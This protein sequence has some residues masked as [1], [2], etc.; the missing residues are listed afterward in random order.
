MNR[1]YLMLLISAMTFTACL[2]NGPTAQGQMF[3][4]GRNADDRP[5][6]AEVMKTARQN[7]TEKMPVK[8]GEGQLIF[9]FPTYENVEETCKSVLGESYN[10]SRSSI[11]DNFF[12]KYQNG[13][14]E[15]VVKSGQNQWGQEIDDLKAVVLSDHSDSSN[16]VEIKINEQAGKLSLFS[17]DLARQK[18]HILRQTRKNVSLVTVEGDLFEYMTGETIKDL[19]TKPNFKSTVDQFR[20]A[21]IGL[22]KIASGSKI[23]KWIESILNFNDQDRQKFEEAFPDLNSKKF[24]LRKQAAKALSKDIAGHSIAIT[25]ML[26]SDDLPLE[27]RARFVEAINNSDDEETVLMISTIVEEKLNKSPALLTSLLTQQ[28]DTKASEDFIANT[29]A[30]LEK[31][32][33]QKFGNDVAAWKKWTDEN[34]DLASSQ[35]DSDAGIKSDQPDMESDIDEPKV[36]APP[37]RRRRLRKTGLEQVQKPLKDLLKFTRNDDGRVVID[38]DH[39]AMACDGKSPREM[40]KDAKEAFESS[41]LPKSWL[42]LGGQHSVAGLG[43]EQ[44]IFDRIADSVKVRTRNEVHG[45]EESKRKSLNRSMDK[46]NLEMKLMVHAEGNRWEDVRRKRAHFKFLFNDQVEDLFYL[47]TEEESR[48]LSIFVFS[49]GGKT[50]F[51]FRCDEKGKIVLHH[52]ADGERTSMKADSIDQLQNDNESFLDQTIV[53]LLDSIGVSAEAVF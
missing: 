9:D 38:R 23:E 22:P 3:G 51:S 41:G 46:S 48:G 4:F 11:G 30:Q 21:G 14:A 35:S 40:L 12:G 20:A 47:I 18:I 49:K 53:P 43:H 13:Q 32:T 6:S 29:V 24:K 52:V 50:I 8:F 28:T 45:F 39:W 16:R 19:V 31:V 33:G 26:V 27:M 37:K 5:S 1:T 7:M 36:D 25:A 17:I 34:V 2:F 44:I 42:T 10:S 15:I